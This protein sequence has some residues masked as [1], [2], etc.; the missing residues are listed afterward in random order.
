[1]KAQKNHTLN[2][3]VFS[4][5]ITVIEKLM[6]IGKVCAIIIEKR[7]LS[8]E[9]VNISNLWDIQLH[10]ADTLPELHPAFMNICDNSIGISFGSGFIFKN[11]HINAFTHGIINFHTGKLP[12]NRGRHPIAWS[13]YHCDKYF[14]LTSHRINEKID[15]GEKIIE[16]KIFRSITDTTQTIINKISAELQGDFIEKTLS[17]LFQNKTKTLQKGNYHPATANKFN[18]IQRADYTAKQIFSIF[19]SQTHYGNVIVDGNEY[20]RCEFYNS[21]ISYTGSYDLITIDN[22][23]LILFK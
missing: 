1:M 2:F 8:Q 9:I 21:D 22:E 15:Q 14:Y 20:K 3:Y 16:R 19:K 12:E 7:Q 5:N 4:S 10:Y 18:S 11:M 23:T 6:Q 13:F 17:A